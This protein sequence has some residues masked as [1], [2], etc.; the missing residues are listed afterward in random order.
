MTRG[1]WLCNTA[2]LLPM[3]NSS[4]QW[5]PLASIAVRS[6]PRGWRGATMWHFT[7]RA[8]RRS[9]LDFAL[10]DGV[11]REASRSCRDRPTQSR[12]LVA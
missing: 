1:G 7:K 8:L 3:G 10:A 5:R 2:I 4:I 12:R 6:V 11:T 9:A